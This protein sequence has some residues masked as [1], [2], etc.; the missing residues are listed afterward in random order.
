MPSQIFPAC[1]AASCPAFPTSCRDA[2]PK[3]QNNGPRAR[4]SARRTRSFSAGIS[5]TGVL[6]SQR[7]FFSAFLAARSFYFLSF[8]PVDAASDIAGGPDEQ[9]NMEKMDGYAGR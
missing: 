9:Q 3:L 2:S 4:N 8:L 6:A 7:F 5:A 1:R